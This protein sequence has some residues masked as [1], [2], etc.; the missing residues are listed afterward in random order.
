MAKP[1]Y[2]AIA[3]GPLEEDLDMD[4]GLEGEEMDVE[5]PSGPT[6][7]MLGYAEALGLDA[8]ALYSFVLA[9]K[10]QGL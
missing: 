10:D 3:A 6:E 1:D 4:M 9:V 7:E 8:D 5:T 2:S